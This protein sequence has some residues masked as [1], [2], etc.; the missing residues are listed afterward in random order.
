MTRFMTTMSALSTSALAS[1]KS[2][3]LPN[4]ILEPGFAEQ[5][6][7]G[8]L[9]GGCQLDVQRLTRRSVPAGARGSASSAATAGPDHVS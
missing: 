6:A 9:V 3:S 1:A 2:I 4:A 5:R 7:S 8:L